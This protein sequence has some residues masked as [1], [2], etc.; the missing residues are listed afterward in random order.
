MTETTRSTDWWGEWRAWYTDANR[1]S[2]E[3]LY[4]VQLDGKMEV[5][6]QEIQMQLREKAAL[7]ANGEASQQIEY[8]MGSG[9]LY[10]I[11]LFT[12]TEK[13]RWKE[14][15]SKICGDTPFVGAQWNAHMRSHAPPEVFEDAVQYRPIF[16]RSQDP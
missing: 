12:D 10:H 14:R 15:L 2:N 4:M 13:A 3:P 6:P 7:I 11:R 8:D 5:Y 1:D 16:I 9:W